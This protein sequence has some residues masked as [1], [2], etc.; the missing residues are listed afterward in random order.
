[1]FKS[2]KDWKPDIFKLKDEKQDDVN[3]EQMIKMS[4]QTVSLNYINQHER[5]MGEMN[6]E[7]KINEQTNKTPT[8]PKVCFNSAQFHH[9]HENPKEVGKEYRQ[10]LGSSSCYH[11]AFTGSFLSHTVIPSLIQRQLLLTRNP[12]ETGFRHLFLPW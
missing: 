8:K 4:P 5:A 7:I 9:F 11:Q 12:E 2:Y 10:S 6:E 1:M 3:Q